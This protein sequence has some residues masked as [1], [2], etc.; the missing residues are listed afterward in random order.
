VAIDLQ[1]TPAQNAFRGEVRAWMAAHVPQTPL[2]T[3]EGAVGFEQHRVW[4]RTLA[5]GNYGCIT[6]PT[7]YGG[8]GANLIEWLIF[9]EEYY[10]ARAPLRVN[11]N[12]I[13]LFG[14]TLMEFGTPEQKARFLP[15]MA[16]GDYIRM[17][18]GKPTRGS[19]GCGVAE[20]G[21]L[22]G[23]VGGAVVGGPMRGSVGGAVVGNQVEGNMKADTSYEIRVRLDDGTL[24]T[25]HQHSVPP[26]S[27]AWTGPTSWFARPWG[28]A[29]CSACS[30]SPRR[31]I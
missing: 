3:L 15:K 1:F 23:S 19:V 4:E 2:A 14:P 29:A 31:S 5:T 6:W 28:S 10:R 7:E 18:D 30:S 22:R 24:R 21:P 16:S 9:E 27:S 17:I 11:Q 13:F 25:F 26:W 20:R 8:R 12:G